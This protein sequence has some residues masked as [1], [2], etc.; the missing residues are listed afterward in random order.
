MSLRY[1]TD[2]S[3]A[4]TNNHCMFSNTRSCTEW[5]RDIQSERGREKEGGRERETSYKHNS[6]CSIFSVSLRLLTYCV[7]ITVTDLKQTSTFTQHSLNT[8]VTEMDWTCW[9]YC[10]FKVWQF[11]QECKWQTIQSRYK[12]GKHQVTTTCTEHYTNSKKLQ[13]Y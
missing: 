8:E 4:L 3:L 6:M 13:C 1:N 12:L 10:W 9:L 11:R 7:H 5:E 2:A